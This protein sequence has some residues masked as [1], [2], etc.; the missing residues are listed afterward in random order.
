MN[1]YLYLEDFDNPEL[2]GYEWE[3]Q[4]ENAVLDYNEEY[5]TEHIPDKAIKNYK[6]WKRDKYRTEV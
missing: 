5:N 1:L 2:E 4:M 6:S 3:E